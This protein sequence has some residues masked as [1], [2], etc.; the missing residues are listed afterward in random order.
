MQYTLKLKIL[1]N[2]VL[3]KSLKIAVVF[4]IYTKKNLDNFN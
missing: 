2:I 1:R 4:L 3:F